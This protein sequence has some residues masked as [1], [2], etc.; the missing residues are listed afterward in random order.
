VP[1]RATINRRYH[2]RRVMRPLIIAR[3]DTFSAFNERPK[4]ARSFDPYPRWPCPGEVL[5][6]TMTTFL[7]RNL[8]NSQSPVS[9]AHL[10]LF[11]L[12]SILCDEHEE[13]VI[14]RALSYFRRAFRGRMTLLRR[15]SCSIGNLAR[16]PGALFSPRSFSLAVSAD[17]GSRRDFER[18]RRRTADT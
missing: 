12:L 17:G 15:R 11:P 14:S 9:A 6:A 10:S 16:F 13:R 7:L 1:L 3:F 5:I 4:L 18:H 2:R 8:G